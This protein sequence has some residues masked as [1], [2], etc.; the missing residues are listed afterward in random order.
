[1]RKNYILASAALAILTL[2]S[3]T[4]E[5]EYNRVQWAAFDTKSIGV[6]ENV[7]TVEVDLSAYNVTGPCQVTVSTS[8]T[9]K[10]GENFKFVGNESGVF[11]FT[12]SGSQKIKIEII[13]HPHEKNGTLTLVLTINSVSEGM[14]IGAMKT[15]TIS[16]ADY[17]PVDW[18]FVT[19][20]WMAQDYDSGQ[21]DG[22]AYE[23]EIT[24][25]DD[26]T[27]KLYNLWGG[28]ETLNATI[29]F[30]SAKNTAAIAIPHNQ[31]VTD[32]SAYGYGNLVIL[33]QNDAGSWAY[34]PVKASVTLSGISIGPWNMLI[35]EGEYS[36]YLW[37]SGAYTTVLTRAE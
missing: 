31:I 33:G 4:K 1:M 9:A 12:E 6:A 25:V 2:V 8:G 29:A 17:V 3:C 7:G 10:A 18:V 26:K 21:P 16:I 37:T 11:N 28:E 13:N 20:T 14:F 36:G 34:A 19:G 30:D 5:M 22:S 23:V 27:L 35:T 32:A 24:K 15:V